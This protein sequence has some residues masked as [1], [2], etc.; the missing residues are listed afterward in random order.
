MLQTVIDCQ[1]NYLELDDYLNKYHKLFIVCSKSISKTKIGNHLSLLNIDKVYFTNFNPNPTYDS[2][3]LGVEEFKQSNAD[4]I[5]A[6]GGGS[7]IDVAKCIK[8]FANMDSQKNYLNQ[9]IVPN[10]LDLMAIPTTAGTG[11]EATSFAVIYYEGEKKSVSD[12]SIIPNIVVFDPSSLDTL[13]VYQ[14]K[15]TMLDA[16]SHAIESYWSVNATEESQKYS[17]DA[18]KLIIKNMDSY[19]KNNKI[20]NTNM[21]KAANIA[22]K[23]INISKTTAGHALCYKLTSI[24]GIAHGHAAA[25]VNSILYPYMI[26]YAKS[27][28][29]N[30]LLT[31]LTKI[32]NTLG[33]NDLE[34]S[35]D[36]LKELLIKLDLY[37]IEI[38]YE[39]IDALSLSVNIERL[40]NFPIRLTNDNIKDI[41]TSIFNEIKGE[42]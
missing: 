18:M 7:A 27:N 21:L 5:I 36:Y 10:N 14:R 3:L 35:K 33:Y 11:S 40:N 6:L 2:V 19:L 39:D 38:N 8:L 34:S 13:P 26:T 16:L 30:K 12:A 9:K 32:S 25:L 42:K 24:Y 31:I 4:I 15:A 20:G 29:D 17:L 37:D 22:G 1:N 28:N 23:A 41:Y